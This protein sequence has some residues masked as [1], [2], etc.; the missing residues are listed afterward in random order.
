MFD[1]LDS[2]SCVCWIP[3]Y[4][5]TSWVYELPKIRLTVLVWH[6][7]ATWVLVTSGFDKGLLHNNTKP[8]PVPALTYCQIQQ[9]QTDH[10]WFVF[11]KQ[12]CS[13]NH[14]GRVT[15]ICVGN[16]TIIGSDNGLSPGRR[17]SHYL[18]QYCLIVNWTL[19]K[20]LQWNQNKKANVLI[21]KNAYEMPPVRWRPFCRRGDELY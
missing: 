7:K 12:E 8:L 14:W 15:H 19:G 4:Q 9:L 6:Q 3:Q 5:T 17:R 2:I 18:N 1:L 10:Y 16:L 11:R 13:L 21:H 20:K